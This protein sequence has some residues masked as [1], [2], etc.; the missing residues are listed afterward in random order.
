MNAANIIFLSNLRPE[1][2]VH[3]V[4]RNLVKLAENLLQRKTVKLAENLLK[5]IGQFSRKFAAA[6]LFVANS[7]RFSLVVRAKENDSDYRKENISIPPGPKFP[8]SIKM[9]P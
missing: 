4:S 1:S 8:A 7:F 9:G 3:K 2:F 5:P 6:K